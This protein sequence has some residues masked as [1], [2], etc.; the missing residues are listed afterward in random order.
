[1]DNGCQDNVIGS[2]G[3][4][5]YMIMIMIIVQITRGKDK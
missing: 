5:G 4:S 3:N 2:D 1:M